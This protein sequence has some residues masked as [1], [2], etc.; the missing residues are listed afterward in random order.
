MGRLMV[1]T[2]IKRAEKFGLFLREGAPV[3]ALGNCLL[4]SVK[5][6]VE[7]RKVFD[8]KITESI[9]DLRCH[10][11][12]EGEKVIGSSPYRIE[13]YTDEDWAMNWNML[14]QRGVWNVEYF[15]DLMIIAL[16]HYI[17]KNI[18]I[19]NTDSS[20][21]PITVIL[22]DRFGKPLNSEYPVILAYNGTHYENL[23]PKTERD[24]TM[25]R[26]IIQKYIKNEDLYQTTEESVD[27]K[28]QTRHIAI[29]RSEP[30]PESRDTDCTRGLDTWTRHHPSN[31]G[32]YTSTWSRE[33]KPTSFSIPIQAYCL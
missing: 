21:A 32:R 8:K 7:D 3:N 22:G 12:E 4:E 6:N 27:I 18:L 30:E 11:A 28:I 25:S 13:E 15:G 16:A 5:V 29:Q 31:S 23:I 1:E 9:D 2:A 19:I 20:Y 10:C 17:G 33:T 24:E 14:K 26:K